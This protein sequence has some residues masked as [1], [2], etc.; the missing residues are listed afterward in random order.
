MNSWQEGKWDSNTSD[1]I[2]ILIN[3]SQDDHIYKRWIQ[4]RQL[5]SFFPSVPSQNKSMAFNRT[6]KEPWARATASECKLNKT[7]RPAELQHPEDVICT[8]GYTSRRW[9]LNVA[10]SDTSLPSRGWWKPASVTSEHLC[11][12]ALRHHCPAVVTILLSAIKVQ[13]AVYG[14]GHMVWIVMRTGENTAHLWCVHAVAASKDPPTCCEL[15]MHNVWQLRC[16]N[17]KFTHAHRCPPPPTKSK[18]S[19]RTRKK[20]SAGTSW[21][22]KE[23]FSPFCSPKRWRYATS[24]DGKHLNKWI[25]RQV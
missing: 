10:P 13:E 19:D 11:R 14:G 7:E 18:A 5:L 20:P 8:A 9:R 25:Y 15:S 6:V 24:A 16:N 22:K 1:I 2:L 4:F 23:M 21:H 17:V 12:K 3:A